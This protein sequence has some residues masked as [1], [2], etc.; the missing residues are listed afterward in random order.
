MAR[1]SLGLLAQ[2]ERERENAFCSSDAAVIHPAS[3]GA[4]QSAPLPRCVFCRTACLAALSV[5]ASQH[6]ESVCQ[7]RCTRTR[8]C[9]GSLRVKSSFLPWNHGRVLFRFILRGS[10]LYKL[11][12]ACLSKHV[13]TKTK[14]ICAVWLV[15]KVCFAS[16]DHFIL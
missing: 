3:F 1:A 4:T 11:P 9:F 15:M 12:S 5:H 2:R 10:F 7:R 8:C 13:F 6:P 14:W 16:L